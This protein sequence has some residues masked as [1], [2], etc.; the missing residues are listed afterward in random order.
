[1][2]LAGCSRQDTECL[3]RIGRKMLERTQSATDEVGERL[4]A[5]WKN[6]RTETGLRD[7]VEARLRWEKALVETNVEVHVTGADVE[8]RGS[9]HTP[10]QRRRAVELAET[11]DGVAKVTAELRVED[12]T[13]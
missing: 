8:L 4:H 3:G 12:E 7:R 2:L 9:V 10:E 11:T 13:K 5:G 1:M 6:V